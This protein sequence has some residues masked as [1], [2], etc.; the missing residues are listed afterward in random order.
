[1]SKDQKPESDFEQRLRTELKA[2]VVERRAAQAASEAALAEAATPAW[3]RG[4]RLALGG[5]VVVAALAGVLAINAGGDNTPAAFAVEPQ[6]GGGETFKIYSLRDAS[7][8]EQ[9]LEDA[10][11][12]AQVT[13]LPAGMACREP[14]YTPSIIHL[15]DGGTQFGGLII[16]GPGEGMTFGVGPTERWRERSQ[17]LLQEHL[18]GDIPDAE[19]ER[20]LPNLNLDPE[21]FRPDQSLVLY[22]SPAPYDGD[23]EG[24]YEAKLQAAEGPVEPCEPVPAD[25]P[26]SFR[27]P[28]EGR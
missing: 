15:P 24:G 28:E 5:G 19:E 8:L 20:S 10:G 18:H 2:V 1:V 22:G 17:E 25:H 11:I 13:W 26:A 27:S 12:Q 14:H 21:A 16:G 7:G 9:A 6:E 3:R 23:P 4:Q